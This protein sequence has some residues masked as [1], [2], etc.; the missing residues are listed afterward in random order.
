[1]N[2]RLVK[3]NAENVLAVTRKFTTIVSLK[4]LP[5]EKFHLAKS[6]REQK[7]YEAIKANFLLSHAQNPT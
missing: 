7:F 1:V 5:V 4:K 3:E 2:K 6:V